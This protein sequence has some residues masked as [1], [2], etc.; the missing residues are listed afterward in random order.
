MMVSVRR[1]LAVCALVTAVG[2]CALE[3]MEEMEVELGQL[4]F[5]ESELAPPPPGEVAAETAAATAHKLVCRG[6]DSMEVRLRGH[7]SQGILEFV[8]E[9]KPGTG[10]ASWGNLAQGECRWMD[11][12]FTWDEPQHICQYVDWAEMV[13]DGSQREI[14]GNS[15]PQFEFSGNPSGSLLDDNAYWYFYVYNDYY[16]SCLRIYSVISG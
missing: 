12:A 6:D 15:I 14:E 8:A 7:M 16:G 5:V 4:E 10:P 9:I 11:R 3:E 1:S 13:I 2:G